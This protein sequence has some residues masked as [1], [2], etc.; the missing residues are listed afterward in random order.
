MTT[1]TVIAVATGAAAVLYFVLGL[2]R[3]RVER[4]SE[5]LR[6]QQDPLTDESAVESGATAERMLARTVRWITIQE[7]ATI[8]MM[9]LGGCLGAMHLTER[10]RDGTGEWAPA[11]LILCMIAIVATLAIATWAEHMME[12]WHHPPDDHRGSPR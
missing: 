10:A 7:R 2:L 8:A 4:T 3:E 9:A 11:V 1:E 12:R 5:T 6:R